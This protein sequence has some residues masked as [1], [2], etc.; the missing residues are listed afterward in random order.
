MIIVLVKRNGKA[1]VP[2]GDTRLREH[3]RIVSI[4]QQPKA[5]SGFSRCL[6]HMCRIV[7]PHIRGLGTAVFLQ[8][9]RAFE[10][11]HILR[12]QKAGLSLRRR[13]IQ[14]DIQNPQMV[15]PPIIVGAVIPRISKKPVQCRTVGLRPLLRTFV[16]LG[17]LK[18]DGEHI[19]ARAVL[20][21]EKYGRLRVRHRPS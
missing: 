7:M 3:D 12:M 8:P 16:V 4:H 11:I 10:G 18:P 13:R 21:V 6:F 15:V 19:S 1:F 5:G 14:A 20:P 9:A 17:V 2:N